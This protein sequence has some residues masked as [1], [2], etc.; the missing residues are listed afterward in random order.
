[1]SNIESFDRSRQCQEQQYDRSRQSLLEVMRPKSPRD[2]ALPTPTIERLQKMI[3]T[4]STMNMLFH[5]KTGTG[6][7]SAAHLFDSAA[8]RRRIVGGSDPLFLEWDGLAVKSMDFVKK[9]IK[10][11]LRSAS[12]VS[13]NSFKICFL[14]RADLIPEAAQQAIPSIIE[15]L[16]DICRFIFAVNDRSKVIP[17]I[18]SRLMPVCFDIE[19]CDREE[20]KRR[21]IDRYERNLAENGIVLEKERLVEIVAANYPNLRSIANE[22]EFELA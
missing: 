1:M 4:D 14:D 20:V 19:P 5:G 17:A 22:I 9:D 3:E 15:D 6:K 7:T 11:G 16:S 12:F 21:L 8:S 2:L 13:M 18:R 10:R